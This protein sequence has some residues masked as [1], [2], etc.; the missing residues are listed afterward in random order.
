ML[1]RKTLEA[2]GGRKG[3]RVDRVEWPDSRS[4]TLSVHL[5]PT[6]KVLRCA[7][8]GGHWALSRT[9]LP[10]HRTIRADSNAVAV[11]KS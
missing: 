7:Q 4:R 9:G 6:A 10:M 5:K 1:N 3:Y 11:Q 8:C 2:V